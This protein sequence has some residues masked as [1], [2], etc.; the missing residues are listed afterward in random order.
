MKILFLDIDGVVNS[1][2]SGRRNH[3]LIEPHLAF[4]VRRIAIAIPDLKV[5]LS[6]SWRCL[7]N[8]REIVEK[9]IIRCFDVTPILHDLDLSR[10][11]EIQAW[12]QEHPEVEKYA[13]IDDDDHMLEHQ[14]V[15]FFQTSRRT[16]ITPEVGDRV[17][18]HFTR[19]QA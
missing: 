1:T 16:G 17:V 13:I 9:K 6:S 19:L 18:A 10:G 3:R 15:N 14:M 12:L 11:H 8:G 4:I 7:D 2:T 5:V